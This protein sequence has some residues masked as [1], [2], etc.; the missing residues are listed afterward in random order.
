MASLVTTSVAGAL[1][2]THPGTAGNTMVQFANGN[3][4]LATFY[5]NNYIT[6]GG[7]SGNSLVCETNG[8]TTLTGALNLT[9]G[10]GDGQ[11]FLTGS[12]TNNSTVDF[13]NATTGN[14]A[15]IYANNAKSLI[16]RTNGATTA[17]TLGGD[18]SATFAGALTGTTATFT[19]VVTLDGTQD[20]ELS[21]ASAYSLRVKGMGSPS[22]AG[23]VLQSSI[24]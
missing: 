17:L 19:G 18:Q 24:Y 22:A 6:M 10:S 15:D 8:N 11:L 1:T 16:F 13:N 9:R 23:I 2:V 3:G 4:V 7:S 5:Q 12:G 14:L 21:A 20:V